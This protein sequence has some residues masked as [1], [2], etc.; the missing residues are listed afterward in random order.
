MANYIDIGKRKTAKNEFGGFSAKGGCGSDSAEK[1][2]A[3]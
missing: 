2:G 1:G 3:E